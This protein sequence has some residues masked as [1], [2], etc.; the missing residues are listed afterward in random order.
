MPTIV[1]MRSAC[2]PANGTLDEV[3]VDEV[4]VDEMAVDEVVV[5]VVAVDVVVV[6]GAVDLL[7]PALTRAPLS[8]D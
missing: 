2:L 6:D 8:A 5:D 4:A 3:A 1:M 7:T